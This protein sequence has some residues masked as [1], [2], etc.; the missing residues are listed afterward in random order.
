MIGITIVFIGITSYELSFLIRHKRKPRTY[1]ITGSFIAA[2]YLY[3]AAI[4]MYQDLPSTNQFIEYI[5][6]FQ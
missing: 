1:W 3:Q 4:H 5:F 6:N 2:A